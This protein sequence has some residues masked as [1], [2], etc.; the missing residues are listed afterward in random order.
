[1]NFDNPEKDGQLKPEQMPHRRMMVIDDA[2]E[3]IIRSDRSVVETNDG[4]I[5]LYNSFSPD[6]P[7]TGF[8]NVAT[9]VAP[10]DYLMESAQDAVNAAF[11]RDDNAIAA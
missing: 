11:D 7:V 10:V 3:N 6:V 9:D 1:M 5:A 2:I 8:E 4:V